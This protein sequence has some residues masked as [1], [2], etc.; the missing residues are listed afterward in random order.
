MI[1]ASQASGRVPETSVADDCLFHDDAATLAFL[2]E[3]TGLSGC[4]TPVGPAPT[5]AADGLNE[6]DVSIIRKDVG[7]LLADVER[8]LNLARALGFG[9]LKNGSE[10]YLHAIKILVLR[11][12]FGVGRTEARVQ[13]AAL[14]VL[15]AC[16]SAI[17]A[18]QPAHLTW[19]MLVAST[20][21]DGAARPWAVALFDGLR[22]HGAFDVDSAEKLARDVW[23]RLDRGNDWADWRAV[24]V[25]LDMKVLCVPAIL[26]GSRPSTATR[27]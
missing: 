7:V 9:R 25:D 16:S 13:Q 22:T 12:V 3:T 23:A 1:R 14:A 20:Q 19:P 27:S 15:E 10:A 24:V 6:P 2:R 26:R 11:H 18:L 21:T 8:E 4:S 5:T 17:S